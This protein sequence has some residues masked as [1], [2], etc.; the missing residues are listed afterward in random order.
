M[1]KTCNKIRL[2]LMGSLNG[3]LGNCASRGSGFPLVG[4]SLRELD[5]LSYL[6]DKVPGE[7]Q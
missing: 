1:A 7:I 2:F 6:L 4:V 5:V 3:P